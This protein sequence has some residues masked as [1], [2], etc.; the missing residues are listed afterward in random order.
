MREDHQ[1]I[2]K[3]QKEHDDRFYNLEKHKM[4]L[5]KEQHGKKIMD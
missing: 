2:E 5:E 3:E 1:Q 4:D